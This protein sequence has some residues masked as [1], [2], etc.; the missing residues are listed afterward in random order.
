ME[1]GVLALQGAISEHIE[2]LKNCGVKATLVKK[3]SDLMKIDGLIIPG[4]ESTTIGK[5]ILAFGFDK[6]IKK[7]AEEGMGIFGT[8]A[9]MILLGSEI[10]DSPQQ[11]TLKLMNIKVK[12]NAFGRQKESSELKI[13]VKGFGEV[14][15]AIFIRAPIVTEVGSDVEILA[16][17]P[18]R[19][20]I[21]VKEGKFLA[22][23]FHP[24]LSSDRRIHK[25][26][27]EVIERR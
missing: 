18:Q 27:I 16:Q 24:E 26:F 13:E 21:L 22:S 15:N 8:C 1:V 10:E 14:F 12:R 5:L 6:L 17:H 25:Y 19:G 23:S 7:R 20:S 3:P 4:G 11:Y 9:G 2:T